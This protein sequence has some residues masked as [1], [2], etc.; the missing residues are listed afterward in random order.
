L[1]A[2]GRAAID[3][4]LAAADAVLD[5]SSPDNV[6]GALAKV[7]VRHENTR[8]LMAL[9][10][11][12]D[13]APGL[14][15]LFCELADGIVQRALRF[16]DVLNLEASEAD[17]RLLHSLLVGLAVLDLATGRPDGERR[18][19]AVLTTALAMIANG[20]RQELPAPQCV[21]KPC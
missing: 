4:H 7:V 15:A 17:A 18:A 12:A 8:I 21:L 5:G 13:Q 16:L 19:A 10:Q 9:A 20:D 6:A 3:G 1:A 14:R 11:A 2:V